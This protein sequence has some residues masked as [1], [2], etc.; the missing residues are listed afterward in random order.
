ML[1]VQN[2]DSRLW[3]TTTLYTHS[4]NGEILGS[5]SINKDKFSGPIESIEDTM[6]EMIVNNMTIYYEYL[7]STHVFLWEREGLFYNLYIN[8]DVQEKTVEE[9]IEVL[10]GFIK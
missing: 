9:L 4:Y 5:F 8:S 3:G 1:L 7:G 10:S 6:E 2:E